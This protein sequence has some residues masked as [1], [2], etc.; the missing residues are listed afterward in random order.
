[1]LDRRECSVLYSGHGIILMSCDK[2]RSLHPVDQFLK[3]SRGGAKAADWLWFRMK[4]GRFGPATSHLDRKD[5]RILLS[6]RCVTKITVRVHNQTVGCAHEVMLRTK[7][8]FP[9]SKTGE[10]RDGRY[11]PQGGKSIGP[12]EM[13]RVVFGSG[14]DSKGGFFNA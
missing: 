12:R 3:G 5:E 9:N 14:N 13:G 1:M 7:S 4:P 2:Q 8:S 6:Q 10:S 11:F